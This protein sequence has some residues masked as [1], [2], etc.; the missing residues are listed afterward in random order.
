M[1]CFLFVGGGVVMEHWD[2]WDV[3]WMLFADT[4][5]ALLL[6]VLYSVPLASKHFD[7]VEEIKA[8]DSIR[9]T[10][11][12]FVLSLKTELYILVNTADT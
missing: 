12:G 10:S 11:S 1:E 3:V 2:V 8:F 7:V 9:L 4:V 6:T 5:L